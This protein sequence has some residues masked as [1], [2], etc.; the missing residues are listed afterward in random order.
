MRLTKIFCSLLLASA[1][2][3]AP[4]SDD[5]IEISFKDLEIEDFIKTV[6]KIMDKNVLMTE[7][8]KGKINFISIRPLDKRSLYT[9][10]I[11]T[12][13]ARGYTVVENQAGFLNVVRS[14][15]AVKEN[16]PV[17]LS[18]SIPQ[19]VTEIIKL[20]NEN[21]DIAS[22]KIRHMLSK[23]GKLVTSKETNT[24][25]ISEY[26]EN[27]DT[28]R[29]VVRALEK[30]A[31]MSV[32]FVEL[33]YA[34]V[35]KI[36][37]DVTK[38]AKTI[39]NQRIDD[40]LIEVLKNDPANSLII[41]GKDE[42]IKKLIP[43]IEQFDK[44]DDLTAQRVEIIPLKNGETKTVLGVVT[45]LMSKKVYPQGEVVKVSAVADDSLNAIILMGTPE[46]IEEFRPIVEQLDVER[47]QVYVKA[48]IIEISNNKLEEFGFKY[49]LLTT[50][51]I[52]G[53]NLFSLSTALGDGTDIAA[54][55]IEATKNIPGF[56]LED[57]LPTKTKT[58]YQ[59]VSNKTTNTITGETT[60]TYESQPMTE[61]VSVAP[62]FGLAVSL[63]LLDAAGATNKLSE[64]SILCINNQE[65]S[66]YVGETR[67][68]STG[69]VIGTTTQNTTAVE[70]VGLT[71]KIKPRLSNDNK[72]L[73]DVSAKLEDI[74]PASTQ[75]G[76][77]KREVVTK[78]IV[79]NGESVILGGLIRDSVQ[80]VTSKVPL[81][82]DI[83]VVG[84][85]LF[86]HEK[87][88]L[89]KINLV[90][91]LT[92]YIIDT[93]ADLTEFKKQLS[94]LN[95]LEDNYA[96]NVLKVLGIEKDGDHNKTATAIENLKASGKK[97]KSNDLL[98]PD[99]ERDY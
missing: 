2:I 60:T 55:A 43:Y 65:S 8:I 13:E 49:G 23:N 74:I 39:F 26:P 1:L 62:D 48:K 72:V 46:D 4:V 25:I 15:D 54:A 97:E 59:T 70:D 64:P 14:S 80:G 28:I 84:D 58:T 87:K 85:L 47:Q 78:A 93:S 89:D 19:M 79:R 40:E 77:T 90:I 27:I 56:D 45:N 38:I 31:K 29:K 3:G 37:A 96:Q 53:N 68:V 50:P 81:L 34:K 35:N 71:L 36:L 12:L 67:R 24:M 42:N 30:Q 6:A 41:I 61:T 63:S 7:S 76:T 66:I 18:S 22:S 92:P 21:V 95:Q 88:N 94:Q 57:M 91:I 33:K 73:L 5:K 82:G 83:P 32:R 99:Y 17:D 16:L 75:N 44:K 51:L 11:Q 86:S 9:L 69:S 10:L 98:T 20:E 52:S